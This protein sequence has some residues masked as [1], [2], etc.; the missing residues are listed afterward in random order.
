M[1][2]LTPHGTQVRSQRLD[3]VALGADQWSPTT[4]AYELLNFRE[5]QTGG[6]F[7]LHHKMTRKEAEADPAFVV[8][9]AKREARR[10][11]NKCVWGFK[12]F[13]GQAATVSQVVHLVD[14]CIIYR[15]ANTTAQC[16]P[17]SR[18]SP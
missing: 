5:D 1:P 12:L 10:S 3:F 13:P 2:T 8:E 4:C 14:K 7:L 18:G 17:R 16:T 9:T 15:R 6:R 11:K